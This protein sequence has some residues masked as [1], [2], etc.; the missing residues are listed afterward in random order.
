M[1]NDVLIVEDDAIIAIDFEATMLEIGVERV[2]TASQT[3]DALA[4]IDE[5]APDFALLDVGLGNE[6]SFDVAAQLD[7]LGIPFAFV[8]GYRADAALA[9]R[10]AGRPI[11]NKPWLREDLEAILCGSPEPAV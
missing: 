2:R 11:L 9:K 10:L 6:T 8:T 4:M 7:E 5:R 3:A 1:P